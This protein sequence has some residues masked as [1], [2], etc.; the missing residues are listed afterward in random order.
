MVAM[1]RR[2]VLIGLGTAAASS[3]A[4][5]GSGAFTSVNADRDVAVEVVDAS[6][7]LL[8]IEPEANTTNL[9]GNSSEFVHV[10]GDSVFTI[11]E[12]P[13]ADS[14]ATLQVE[15]GSEI[16][17]DLALSNNTQNSNAIQF[18]VEAVDGNGNDRSGFIEFNVSNS[19]T[20]TTALL[21]TSSSPPANDTND[22]AG[23]VDLVSDTSSD[24]GTGVVAA[25]DSGST[26]SS[27]YGG[28][29]AAPI[30]VGT[31]SFTGDPTSDSDIV[32]LTFKAQTVDGTNINSGA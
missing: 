9:D 3:G 26:S 23:S 14:P 15:P 24:T 1:N 18:V 20:S 22:L 8:G 16:D 17:I 13:S 19:T 27:D 12:N 21:D 31:V 29:S 10:G 2:N 7:A 11:G 30:E 28:S 25:I 32:T 5:F 6:E 4:V